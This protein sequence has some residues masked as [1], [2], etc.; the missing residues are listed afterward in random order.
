MGISI[1]LFLKICYNCIYKKKG[2]IMKTLETVERILGIL[3]SLATL[4]Q[5]IKGIF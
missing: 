1:D 3:I 5:L 4:V 2:V